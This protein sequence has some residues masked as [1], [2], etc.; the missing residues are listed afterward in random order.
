MIRR[1]SGEAQLVEVV[2]PL[3]AKQVQAALVID[4]TVVLIYAGRRPS[5]EHLA[6]TCQE[7]NTAIVSRLKMDSLWMEF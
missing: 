1:S 4:H 5:L 7:A 6:H 3:A 2:E